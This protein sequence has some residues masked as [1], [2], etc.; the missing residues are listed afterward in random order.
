MMLIMQRHTSTPKPLLLKLLTVRG[1]GRRGRR[2]WGVWGR[3]Q[4]SRRGRAVGEWPGVVGL[5]DSRLEITLLS[6]LWSSYAPISL[7]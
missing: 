6:S 1:E 7:S 2:E 4:G 5:E 3:R